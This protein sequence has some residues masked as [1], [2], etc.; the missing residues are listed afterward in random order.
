MLKMSLLC[1]G[2]PIVWS[3][4]IYKSA[5]FEQCTKPVFG[6]RNPNAE[7]EAFLFDFCLGRSD[8]SDDFKPGIS[9]RTQQNATATQKYPAWQYSTRVAT[10]TRKWRS[11][12]AQRFEFCHRHCQRASKAGTTSPCNGNVR[13]HE[14]HRRHIPK[15]IAPSMAGLGNG[16]VTRRGSGQMHG[17]HTIGLVPLSNPAFNNENN[18]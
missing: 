12:Y 9:D 8:Y 13:A 15:L 16:T 10:T 6:S 1:P 3:G 4:S 2:M 14:G 18:T 11:T 5:Q 7:N 17:S